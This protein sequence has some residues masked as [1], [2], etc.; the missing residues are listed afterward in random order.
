MGLQELRP[1]GLNFI[2][3]FKNIIVVAAAAAVAGGGGGGDGGGGGSG[4]G[5]G[6]CVSLRGQL[7]RVCSHLLPCGVIRPAV[8]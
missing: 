6:V 1:H 3:Y 2:F 5:G 7:A 8:K 4:G